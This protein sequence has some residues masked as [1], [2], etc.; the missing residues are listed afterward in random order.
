ML[1]TVN[2]DRY[3]FPPPLLSV[4]L[5]VVVVFLSPD[6]HTLPSTPSD[7]GQPRPC[8][9]SSQQF[10]PS[11][12]PFPRAHVAFSVAF[13]C[14]RIYVEN[15]SFITCFSGGGKGRINYWNIFGLFSL[16]CLSG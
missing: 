12:S 13:F 14:M 2:F 16:F 1:F 15:L 11:V 8:N 10:L 7:S 3:T 6:A 4:F 5:V 9:N